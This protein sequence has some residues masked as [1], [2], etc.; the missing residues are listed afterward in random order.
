MSATTSLNRGQVQFSSADIVTS[1]ISSI[2][3]QITGLGADLKS[4]GNAISNLVAQLQGMS[5]PKA[6]GDPDDDAAMAAYQQQLAA[7]HS[8]VNNI[9]QQINTLNEQSKQIAAKI[10]QLQGKVQ[11]LESSDLPNAQRRDTQRQEDE[12]K[13]MRDTYE[14]QAKAV[15][16]GGGAGGSSVSDQADK[17]DQKR[18]QM[19]LGSANAAAPTEGAD[20]HL[21]LRVSWKNL[22]VN[23][24][25]SLKTLV[26]AFQLHLSIAG[27]ASDLAR[28]G[29]AAVAMP[30]TPGT[31]LPPVGTP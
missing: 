6:P 19:R 11:Q 18:V 8:Q 26:R 24:S 22:Q 21:Q 3:D 15:E 27:D 13:Q 17:N 4:I 16:A 12:I 29:N 31:G 20:N 5:P 2:D 10:D 28:R 23:D 25:S 7:Y 1:Q 14:A 30:Y 9:Q